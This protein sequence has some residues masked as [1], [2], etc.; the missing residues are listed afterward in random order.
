MPTEAAGTRAKA[1]K[2]NQI[3]ARRRLPSNTKTIPLSAEPVGSPLRSASPR[4]GKHIVISE[5]SQSIPL[6]R[7]T[8]PA[9][10]APNGLSRGD[11]TLRSHSSHASNNAASVASWRYRNGTEALQRPQ[12]AHSPSKDRSCKF[13]SK[14]EQEE[15]K[16]K[17]HEDEEKR[18]A[19]Q[20]NSLRALLNSADG[21]YP[22]R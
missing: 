21:I 7:N 8:A 6:C 4:T 3:L 9:E 17:R 5:A 2:G 18:I 14:R 15:A 13:T 11:E 12:S 20:Q 10:T 1:G 19:R 16:R 22:R